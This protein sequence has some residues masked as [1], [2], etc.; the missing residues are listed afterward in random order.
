VRAEGWAVPGECKSSAAMW[1]NSR[2][3]SWQCGNVQSDENGCDENG[4]NVSVFWA[5][6]RVCGEVVAVVGECPY[7]R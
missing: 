7:R 3:G 5:V 6:Q 4:K 1:R 2:R